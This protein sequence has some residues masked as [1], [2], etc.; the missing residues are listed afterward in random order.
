MDFIIG[1]H[2]AGSYFKFGYHRARTFIMVRG[3]DNFYASNMGV[4]ASGLTPKIAGG[5]MT[6]YFV[7]D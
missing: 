6:K 5:F 3:L 2:G 1:S 7:F 4:T